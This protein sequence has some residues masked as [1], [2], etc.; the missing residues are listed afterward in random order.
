MRL[1]PAFHKEESQEFNN[2]NDVPWFLH[3]GMHP[4]PITKQKQKQKKMTNWDVLFS[5]GQRD[6][7]GSFIVMFH[8]VQ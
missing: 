6:G 1:T 8:D 5:C 3:V 4:M 7:S 2:G